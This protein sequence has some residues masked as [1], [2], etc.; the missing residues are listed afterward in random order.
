MIQHNVH[1][2]L[3][4]QNKTLKGIITNHDLMI[5]QGTSPLSVVKDIENQ[6][7]IEGLIPES[8]NIN[9]IISLLLK[10]G[11]KA[12]NITNIINKISAY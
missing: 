11:A 7:T 10:E 8:K 1:H 2:I 9:R 12:S 5:L 4:M 6:Q 3:V